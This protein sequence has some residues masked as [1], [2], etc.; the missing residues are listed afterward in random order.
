[1]N[2]EEYADRK[3]AE[4]DAELARLETVATGQLATE[5]MARMDELSRRGALAQACES[6]G[7]PAPAGPQ[8]MLALSAMLGEVG[9]FHDRISDR[10]AE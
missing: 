2:A 9:G 1:M 8:L 4:L 5:L 3:L 10:P 7:W 6:L